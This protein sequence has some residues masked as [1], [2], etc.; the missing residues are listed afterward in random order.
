MK[1]FNKM[2]LIISGICGTLGVILLL[3]G[4]LL[5]VTRDEFW[6]SMSVQASDLKSRVRNNVIRE[7][8]IGEGENLDLDEWRVEK[9]SDIKKL[10]V[11]IGMGYLEIQ[12]YDEEELSVYYLKSDDKTKVKLDKKELEIEQKGNM[13]SVLDDEECPVK[14]MIPRDWKFEEADI[15]IGAGEALIENL[16]ADEITAEIGA[17]SLEI[18]GRAQAKESDW[19]VGAGSLYLKELISEKT[20]LECAVG[21]INATLNGTENDYRMKGK[22]GVGSLQFGESE[23]DSVGQKIHFGEETASR[24]VTIDC[25]TGEIYVDFTE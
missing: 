7:V 6:N 15:G 11:N 5:G 2:L 9:F 1:K 3:V 25:G 12:E 17:G 21:E 8:E 19:S 24:M 13:K 20:D 14:I 10:D 18:T 16:N 4:F 23:W 22:L